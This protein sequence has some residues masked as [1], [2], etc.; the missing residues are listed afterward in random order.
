VKE[1]GGHSFVWVSGDKAGQAGKLHMMANA[2][3][4]PACS[5][6][7]EWNGVT[8]ARR[9]KLALTNVAQLPSTYVAKN[10]LLLKKRDE[11]YQVPFGSSP[12]VCTDMKGQ[13]MYPELKEKHCRDILYDPKPE[14][15]V[16]TR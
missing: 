13:S 16:E 10:C 7:G 9:K 8:D 2:M 5:K 3:M 11:R 12:Q 15:Y 6:K 4:L 1:L 14:T